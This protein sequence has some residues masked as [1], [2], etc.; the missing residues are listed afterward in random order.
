MTNYYEVVTDQVLATH[1]ELVADADRWGADTITRMDTLA[2]AVETQLDVLSGT[3]FSPTFTDSLDYYGPGGTRP[4]FAAEPEYGAEGP[5]PPELTE[6]NAISALDFT[7]SAYTGLV[8]AGIQAVINDATAG[9][10]IMPSAVY[11]AMYARLVADFAAKYVG[12][13]WAASERGASLGWGS[14]RSEQT[15]AALARA[16]DAYSKDIAEARLGEF[17]KEWTLKHEDI[18]KGV[19]NGDK[20]ESTWI[21]EHNSGQDRSLK[22]AMAVLDSAIKINEHLIAQDN[23]RLQSYGIQWK[24]FAD[25][26]QATASMFNARIANATSAIASEEGRHRFEATQVDKALKTEDGEVNL[27][28]ENAK[29][30]VQN[31]LQTLTSLMQVAANIGMALMSAQDVS[32]GTGSNFGTSETHSYAEQCCE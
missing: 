12:A 26:I 13:T 6:L 3:V 24:G 2:A 15:A 8:K 16:D 17:V 31:T 14:G 11:D 30:Q 18:W 25:R 28:L 9:T 10:V 20:F 29:L 4:D 19:E 22:A 32:L 7:D 5:N 27:A 23:L 1:N 21:G